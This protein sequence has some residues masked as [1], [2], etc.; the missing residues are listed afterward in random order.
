MAKDVIIFGTQ[1]CALLA[2]FYLTQ[3]KKNVVAFCVDDEYY[4]NKKISDK[5]IIKFSE[6][7]LSYPPDQFDF[8]A[9][10]YSNEQREIVS[11]KIISKGYDLVSYVSPKCTCYGKVGKNCF[12]MEDNTVQPF[13]EIGDNVI[14]WSGNHIG[15]H[16]KIANNVFISSHVVISGHCQVDQYSWLGVNATIKDHVKLSEGSFIGM[17]SCV[18]K[19]TKSFTKYFGCPAKEI[20]I[21]GKN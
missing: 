12:I 16:T 11:N 19:D 4:T 2:E 6:V 18:L 13:V 14:L 21:C 20:G 7:E 8:F 15:H 10:L 9:P 3:D 5:S 17:A 1:D